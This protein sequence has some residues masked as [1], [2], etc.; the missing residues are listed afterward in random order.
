MRVAESPP[1]HLYH[2]AYVVDLRR[3]CMGST[4]SLSLAWQQADVNRCISSL[5]TGWST[6]QPLRAYFTQGIQRNHFAGRGTVSG[7]SYPISEYGGRRAGSI[8]LGH[9]A[10][11]SS[12]CV[13]DSPHQTRQPRTALLSRAVASL[14]WF[15]RMGQCLSR[16][17]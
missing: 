16:T 10:H 6:G 14:S 4:R 11:V 1:H 8:R 15:V 2:A 9:I 3:G 13:Y 12:E 7:V 5:P 17:T